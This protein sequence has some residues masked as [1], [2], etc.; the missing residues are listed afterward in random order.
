MKKNPKIKTY[1]GNGFT[2]NYPG[3]WEDYTEYALTKDTGYIVLGDPETVTKLSDPLPSTIVT[4]LKMEDNTHPEGIMSK[5]MIQNWLNTT[6]VLKSYHNI[7][8]SVGNLTLDESN[9]RKF[10]S[11]LLIPNASVETFMENLTKNIT[12]LIPKSEGYQNISVS[13]RNFTV[14]GV[15]AYEFV[16]I[17][18]NTNTKMRE[19]TRNIVIEK[20]QNIYVI[21]CFT[22]DVENFETTKKEFKMVV[23]SFK[24]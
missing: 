10:A 8:V 9:A 23:N 5:M 17:A 16:F 15:T 24:I 14:D 20:N 11:D 4:I 12:I 18:Y 1:S 7:S 22:V 6:K 3:N 19:Y 13:T 2:F 21:S